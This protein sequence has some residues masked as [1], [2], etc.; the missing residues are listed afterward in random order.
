VKKMKKK[1]MMMTLAMIPVP[2][3]LTSLNLTH[4]L[5]SLIIIIIIIPP[6]MP[7]PPPRCWSA[8]TWMVV[9]T[10]TTTMTFGTCCTGSSARGSDQT[11]S[12]SLTDRSLRENR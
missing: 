9:G 3:T 5:R 1:L 8:M 12:V 4:S 11:W 2:L 6:S 7:A 10:A